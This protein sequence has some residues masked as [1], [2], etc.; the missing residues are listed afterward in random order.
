[1]LT[2]HGDSLCARGLG[3][4]CR[5]RCA[6]T[7]VVFMLGMALLPIVA[8][9][10]SPRPV[11]DLS[12][13]TDPYLQI[14]LE[15]IVRAQGLW[16]QI[17]AERLAVGLVDITDLERPRFAMLNPDLM[18]YAASLPKIAIL[19][20]AFVAIESGDLTPNAKLREAMTDMIRTSDNADATFVLGQIGRQRLLELLTSDRL[21]LYHPDFNGGLWVGKDYAKGSAY[22][23]DPLHGISHGATVRQV[24]RFFYLL[25]RGDLVGEPFRTEMKQILADPGIAHKFV[26]GLED[27]PEARLHRKSGTWRHF[28]ADAALVEVGTYRYIVVGLARHDDG[29]Q[30]LTQLAAPLHDLLLGAYARPVQHGR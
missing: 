19:L 3:L 10:D 24:A 20:G 23:R 17:E 29:G 7:K 12:G 1:M 8:A 14:G 6:A 18:V 5:F 2:N 11:T 16:R 4:A 27:R 30:W 15:R 9:A 28:H 13:A 25:E 26:A 21:R 22:K